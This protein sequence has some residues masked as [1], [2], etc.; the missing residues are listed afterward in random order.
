VVD[1]RNPVAGGVVYAFRE[2][3][4][5]EDGIQRPSLSPWETYQ[6][7]WNNPA[8]AAE[9]PPLAFRMNANP[10]VALQDP[11][12]YRGGGNRR[13]ISLKPVDFY[14]DPERRIHGFRLR[15][16]ADIRR[17]DDNPYG[18]SFVTDN[19]VYLQAER[20]GDLGYF[21]R[22]L[23]QEFQQLLPLDEFYDFTRFYLNRTTPE[24]RFAVTGTGRDMWR[25]AEVLADGITLLS[26]EYCDGYVENG[27]RLINNI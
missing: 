12:L 8:N 1:L 25:P 5:R 18:L 27:V 14:A 11:P 6:A 24:T 15:N 22:H 19:P 3:G 7:Q 16:G 23:F 20:V 2:D 4:M 17:S 10:A 9:G 21:N 13:G 26:P